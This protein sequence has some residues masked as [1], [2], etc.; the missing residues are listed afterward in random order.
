MSYEAQASPKA[1]REVTALN[2]GWFEMEDQGH[3]IPATA[4]RA[5]MVDVGEASG[6]VVKASAYLGDDLAW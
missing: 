4:R 2:D 6:R 1:K 3:L 5:P